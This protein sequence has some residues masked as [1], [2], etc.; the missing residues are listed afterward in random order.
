MGGPAEIDLNFAHVYWTYEEIFGKRFEREDLIATLSETSVED[1]L[2]VLSRL[3]CMV[4]GQPATP[5]ARQLQIVRR[6][7][8]DEHVVSHLTSLIEAQADD[9]PRTLFFPQQ[10]VELTRLVLRHADMRPADGFDNRRLA[11]RFIQCVFG[12]T[13]LL[14]PDLDGGVTTAG[15]RT[16]IL[17]QLGLMS[18]QEPLYLFGRYYE[19]LVRLWPKVHGADS[20]AFEPAVE[21]Q[22]Y[23]GMTLQD[24]FVVGFSVYTRFLNHAD[25][26]TEPA[27][28]ALFPSQYFS[29]TKLQESQWAPFFHLLARTPQQ[30]RE[31][32]AAED[33]QYGPSRYR[34]HT[35]DRSPLVVTTSGAMMPTSFA[36]FE[37]AVT[38]GAFWQLADAAEQQ[39]RSRE[40]F[41]SPFG[42]VFERFAQESLERI[43]ALESPTPPR[44]WRDFRYGPKRQRVLSSDM[45][46]LYTEERAGIF[47]EVVT[48]R[49]SVATSTRGDTT[50]FRSDLRKLVAKKASQLRRC[51]R[52]FFLFGTLSFDGIGRGQVRTIWPTLIL[53]EGFPL[54][55][56][57][58]SEIVETLRRQGWPNTAPRLKLLDADELGALEALAEHGWRTI[59]VLKL[60]SRQAPHLPMSN[61]LIASPD[62]PDNLGHAS[63]HKA[64]FDELSNIV[65][66][67]VSGETA[68]E[69]AAASADA[70]QET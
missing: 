53:I 21:F 35:F 49:P 31:D 43:A 38:E 25:Q 8:V 14:G 47:F 19:L 36:S 61:W 11:G 26:A 66:D 23:T 4:E 64:A 45:T 65:I 9:R 10:L 57:I 70:P 24:F 30:L 7:T 46:Y 22:K 48:G 12:V 62:I 32:L 63:W 59:D 6:M 67:A 69:L 5:S 56:P 29:S 58:Y 44:H 39:G 17:R 27:A 60:W 37:R 42:Q 20:G 1:C 16:F 54:M 68:D 3:S 15:A 18:R 2:E 41:T 51:Y 13:D 33:A 40:A 50:A 55:P 34:C 28:F 52:D